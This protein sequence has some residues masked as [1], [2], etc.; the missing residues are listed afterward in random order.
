MKKEFKSYHAP[1]IYH[2]IRQMKDIYVEMRDGVKLCVD[3]YLPDA[4][5]SFPALLSIG[6][7][8][9]DLLAADLA[10]AKPPQPSWS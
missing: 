8:N 1:A 6:Q 3:I 5:G 2:G 4:D 9:K 10:A 7:H